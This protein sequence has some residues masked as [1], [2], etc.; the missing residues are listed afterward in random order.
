ME[1]P[2]PEDIVKL[3]ERPR[4]CIEVENNYEAVK[5]IILSKI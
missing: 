1:I 4:E 5:E 2:I 3:A